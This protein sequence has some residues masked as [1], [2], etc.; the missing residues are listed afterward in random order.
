MVWRFLKKL[1][2]ELPY[3][4]EIRLLGIYP[5]KMKTLTEKKTTYTM[6]TAVSFTVAKL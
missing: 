4:P 2:T 5:K 3:D 6:F 1:K